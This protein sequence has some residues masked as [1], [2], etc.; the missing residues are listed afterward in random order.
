MKRPQWILMIITGV[1][2]CLLIGIFIGRNLT[3]SY[4]SIPD[5]TNSQVSDSTNKNQSNDGRID[6]NT[7]SL[8]QLQLLPGIGQTIAQ[9]IIDYRTENGHFSTI[10][11]IMNVSGIGQKKF[12]EIKP[13]IKVTK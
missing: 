1:F 7:A 8:Q 12:D 13:Y 5:S 11:D 2:F 10:E 6:I 4:I 9:R 3:Q